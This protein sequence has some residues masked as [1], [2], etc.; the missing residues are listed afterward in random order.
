MI[1]M[2]MR[3]ATLAFAF[4]FAVGALPLF[5]APEVSKV[6]AAQIPASHRVEITYD[7]ANPGGE[8]CTVTV[9]A[10]LD[11]GNSYGVTVPSQALSG[12]VGQVT[13]GLGKKIVLHPGEVPALASIYTKRLRFRVTASE[14][15]GPGLSTF[16]N[17]DVIGIPRSSSDQQATIYPSELTVSGVGPDPGPITVTLHE[18]SHEYASDLSILLVAP[19]EQNVLLLSGA[20]ADSPFEGGQIDLVF[21]DDGAHAP[22]SPIAAGVYRP[23]R[24]GSVP[25]F[26]SP[27]PA[28][29]YGTE[30]A[31]LAQGGVN[32]LWR[33]YI[34]DTW[35]GEDNGVLAGGWSIAFGDPDG[36]TGPEIEGFS[37]IPAGPFTMGRTSG[38]TD[39]IAPP[40]TV[41]V[42]EFYLAKTPVSKALWDEVRAW[43]LQNGYTDLRAGSSKGPDH[44]VIRV[45]WFDVVKWC[46][47]RSEMEE[48]VAPVYKVEGQVMQTGTTVPEVNWNANGYRLP[49]EAEWEKA[50]RGGIAGKR[51]PWGDLIDHSHANYSANGSAHSYD[52]SHYTTSTRHPEYNF[53]VFPYTSPVVPTGSFPSNGFGLYDMAGNVWEWCWDWYA[54]HYYLTTN[55]TTD[56]RG[57]ASGSSRV[58]RGGSWNTGAFSARCSRRYVFGPVSS[59]DVFL[60]LGFRPA[61]SS[62]P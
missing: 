41:T 47:A 57:P 39:S 4:V 6:R 37:R 1:A 7:L 46:N 11:G 3:I 56:P 19:N 45:S 52:T 18:I 2:R 5:A 31:P 50:A 30:I 61:R 54:D 17:T 32:G 43:G 38:D 55:G 40:V 25:T 16:T 10:S 9:E 8:A 42:S 26:P 24:H 27:A 60:S 49:T 59:G 53:G 21:R 33:L 29:P 44:P 14:G 20:G 36:G 13:P 35:P 23:T 58:L 22:S 15:G 34:I 12:D 62:V 51:F 48:G 28:G